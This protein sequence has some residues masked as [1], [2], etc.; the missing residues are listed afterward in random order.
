MQKI[1]QSILIIY[2]K[3]LQEVEQTNTEAFLESN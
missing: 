1:N 2:I 3:Y